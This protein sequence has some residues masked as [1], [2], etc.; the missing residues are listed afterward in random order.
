NANAA[1]PASGNTPGDAA[2]T[3]NFTYDSM[4]RLV[5]AIAPADPVGNYPQTILNYPDATTVERQ[6]KI[7]PG[8]T[9]DA[10][11]YFD[12]LGRTIHAKHVLPGGSNA[13][14]DTTYDALGR[15]ATVTN[16]YFSTSELTYGVTKSQYDALGR[17]TQ[18]TRQDGSINSVSYADNCTT[19]TDEAS[20]QRRAC[21]EA[22]GRLT[23]VWEDPAG[24]NY[25]TDYQYDALGNMLRV[26]QKGSAPTDSTQWR[27][28]R[29]TYDSLSRI[30]TANN[31]ESGLITYF[32][33]NNGNLTQKVMPSPN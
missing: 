8:L 23:S 27:T 21:T 6:H 22:L 29:F 33:D 18:T 13:L 26:D 9:D 30:L 16:P 19:T 31:P 3:S 25:E 12:G 15:A 10:Y 2:H 7:A 14:V 4:W 5:W 1:T 17:I 24:L 11:T 20:K 32:Y 28:R